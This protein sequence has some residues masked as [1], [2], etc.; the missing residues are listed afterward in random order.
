MEFFSVFLIDVSNIKS[1]N[2]YNTAAKLDTR[3]LLK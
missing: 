3:I 2:N 1:H